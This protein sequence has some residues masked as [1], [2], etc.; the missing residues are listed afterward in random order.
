MPSVKQCSKC[1]TSFECKNDATGCWCQQHTL[2][3]E[4]LQ[5][6]RDNFA[7]CLCPECLAGYAQAENASG[8]SVDKPA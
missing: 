8:L 2:S 3:K 4:T 7:N 5:H 6:L 1:N